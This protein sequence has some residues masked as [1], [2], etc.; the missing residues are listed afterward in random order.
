LRL[1]ILH[2]NDIH[3]RQERIAQIATLVERER[4]RADHPVLYLDAGDVEET[5]N[6]LSNLTK[7]T[8]MHRLLS[9]AG[10]DAATV[11]NACW[12]RYGPATLTE[13]A[14]VS[15]YPQLLANFTGIDGPVPGTS[16]SSRPG[17]TGG[18]HR[19][20]RTTST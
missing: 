7:G 4:A 17:T 16:T 12:L 20:S 15:T 18:S 19:S 13:H 5:T 2:T 11:G 6:R 10:C 1:T 8:A 3:G 9:V 14:R